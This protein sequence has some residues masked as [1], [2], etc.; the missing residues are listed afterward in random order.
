ML[1]QFIKIDTNGY[2]VETVLF[3][4]TDNKG[5]E[6]TPPSNYKPMA[7]P[8]SRFFKKKWD[9]VNSAWVEGLSSTEVE[10]KEAFI[11][12]EE[13]DYERL[14]NREGKMEGELAQLQSVVNK[15]LLG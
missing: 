1:K 6:L 13:K 3:E 10:N 11:T 7:D 14:K 12:E 4:T 9:E 5:N 8:S 2:E 15:M